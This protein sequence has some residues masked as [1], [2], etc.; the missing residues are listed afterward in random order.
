MFGLHRIIALAALCHLVST[1]VP[2]Q[3]VQTVDGDGRLYVR[4]TAKGWVVQQAQRD[5]VR[6]LLRTDTFRPYQIRFTVDGWLVAGSGHRDERH[7]VILLRY[8]D[9]RLEQLPLLP[10]P[11]GRVR[12]HPTLL[13]D[14]GRLLGVVWAEGDRQEEYI[15]RSAAWLGTG[16]GTVEEVSGRAPGA[17]LALT[18]TVLDNGDWLVLWSAFDGADDEIVWSRRE[19]LSWSRPQRLHA[20]NR[21]PDITPTLLATATGAVAAWSTYDGNDYRLRLAHFDGTRWTVSGLL[22]ARGS[23]DPL[24][25]ARSGRYLILHRTVVPE[26]WSL[27]EVDT[28]GA[29]LRQ[30]PID[31]Q[32]GEPPLI[33]PTDADGI[34]IVW[35]EELAATPKRPGWS[36][37][38]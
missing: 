34:R 37:D 1:G 10:D 14:E 7:E 33:V 36:L 3:T 20:D 31:R 5:S 15:V 38:R 13:I 30:T 12:I 24:A 9:G 8:A 19:M 16:W 26:G 25:L 29:P 17:Q 11:I 21:V 4:W 28:T 27:V 35:P 22:G 6:L 23:T 2:A 32:G 18:A